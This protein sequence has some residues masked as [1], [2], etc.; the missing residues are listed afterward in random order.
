MSNRGPY[1]LSKPDQL[2]LRFCD[3]QFWMAPNGD[4]V[5][6]PELSTEYFEIGSKYVLTKTKD[7]S[8]VFVKLEKPYAIVPYPPM[9]TNT[10]W[11]K[12]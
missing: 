1:I 5:L 8:L 2:G 10:E 4:L 12:R 3:Y 7:G 9:D 11:P 6:D